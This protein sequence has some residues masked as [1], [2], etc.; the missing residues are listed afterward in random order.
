LEVEEVL[1]SVEPQPQIQM[2][3]VAVED[4]PVELVDGV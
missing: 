1:L 4:I 2:E 3:G